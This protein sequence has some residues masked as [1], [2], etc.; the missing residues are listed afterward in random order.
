MKQSKQ[1]MHIPVAL[2]SSMMTFPYLT[3]TNVNMASAL[4][5]GILA[6]Y[7]T[8]PAL[9]G[10]L[11]LKRRKQSW[12]RKALWQADGEAVT[13]SSAQQQRRERLQS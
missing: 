5:T 11:L 12:E 7:L 9:G 8:D 4:S 6:R 10:L 1:R 2:S 13:A 3:A